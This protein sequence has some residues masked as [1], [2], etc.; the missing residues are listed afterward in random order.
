MDSFRRACV[1]MENAVQARRICSSLAQQSNWKWFGN[2]SLLHIFLSRPNTCKNKHYTTFSIKIDI[3]EALFLIRQFLKPSTV[4][5]NQSSS[6]LNWFTCFSKVN[7]RDFLSSDELQNAVLRN[8]QDFKAGKSLCLEWH[9]PNGLRVSDIEIHPLCLFVT[10]S[11]SVCPQVCSAHWCV[12]R[13][14]LIQ[15]VSFSVFIF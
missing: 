6:L 3:L 4:L 5:C 7:V 14:N 13:E 9:R 1:F 11:L 12:L 15:L 10:S 8:F 2:F